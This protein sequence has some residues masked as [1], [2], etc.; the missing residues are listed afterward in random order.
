MAGKRSMLDILSLFYLFCEILDP[1]VVYQ[2]DVHA[3]IVWV[4]R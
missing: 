3:G 4:R 2:F 1:F